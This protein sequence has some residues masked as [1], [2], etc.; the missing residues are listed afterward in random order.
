MNEDRESMTVDEAL[1]A[2]RR[3]GF[4]V[5]KRTLQRWC[6]RGKL[7]ADRPVGG[8]GAPWRVFTDALPGIGMRS[9][10]YVSE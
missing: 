7:P 5:S 3:A 4:Q 9:L 2:M 10:D 6:E 8:R 1:E